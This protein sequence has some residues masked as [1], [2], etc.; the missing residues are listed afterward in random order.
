MNDRLDSHAEAQRRRVLSEYPIGPG[1]TPRLDRIA[2]LAAQICDTPIGLVSIVEE[3]RQSFVGRFGLDVCDTDREY[4]F[5]AHAMLG[6]Q[7]MI[8]GDALADDR[9]R[10]NPLVTGAPG[11]RFYAGHPLVSPEGIP[12]G[13][14]CVIDQYPRKGL[15]SDQ[16]EALETLA[17]VI[18][19]V[20]DSLRA[21][22]ASRA[23]QQVSVTRVAEL[24]QRFA[25]LADSLPQMVWST[26]PD[27]HTDYLNRQWCEFTGLPAE[28]SYGDGWLGLI[29]PE[30]SPGTAHAWSEAL[31]TGNAYEARYRLKRNDGSYRWVIARGL[32][33]I[34]SAN[35][36]TRWIGTST[37]I[38]D[39]M[40]DAETLELLSQ[41]LSHRIKNIFAVL[42]GLVS[43]SS[44]NHPD[45]AEFASEL[46]NRILALGRAHG[47]IG[48]AGNREAGEGNGLKGMLAEMLKPYATGEQDRIHIT[49][50]N[51]SVDDRSATPLA[52]VFHELATNSAKFGAISSDN[53]TVDISVE[54]GDPIRVHWIERGIASDIERGESGFG[55]RLIDMSIRRQLGGEYETIWSD[56]RLDIIITVP[57]ANLRRDQGLAPQ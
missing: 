48:S 49:G 27:G 36:V 43:L 53:G 9:F 31:A 14:L 50:S 20:L 13:A 16:T 39:E 4:S 19:M 38:D 26:R 5:C 1:S 12:L 52:L 35:R 2:R 7:A 55:A 40:K 11:I 45:A 23:A 56:G 15:S 28:A 47:F 57:Q 25:V 46:Y 34:D 6:Q 8:V 17:D 44:R 21:E 30:D 51:V 33:I 3:E 41:E 24:E 29:H 10:D 18:L 37:D 22:A 54:Q 32:P 42:G